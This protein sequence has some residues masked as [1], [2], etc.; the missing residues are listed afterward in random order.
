MLRRVVRK[1]TAP[2]LDFQTRF[3]HSLLTELQAIDLPGQDQAIHELHQR[4]ESLQDRVSECHYKVESFLARSPVPAA[5]DPQLDAAVNVFIQTR[6][7]EPP[8]H[9]L[10]LSGGAAA[11]G[12]LRD[13]GYIV[14]QAPAAEV[15]DLPLKAGAFRVIL[16]LGSAENE[17]TPL[18][19]PGGAAAR[20]AVARLLAPNGRVFGSTR[21]EDTGRSVDL[22]RAS[23]PL[24]VVDQ[25]ETNGIAVWS[26][27]A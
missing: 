9:A 17:P 18:W 4:L 6:M 25:L 3:N 24:Q 12:M 26:A 2:W 21:R 8:G 5:S 13:I 27:Q 20:A 16:A 14:L 23:A 11:V 22:N 15:Y 7:P 1:L 19:S 10:V